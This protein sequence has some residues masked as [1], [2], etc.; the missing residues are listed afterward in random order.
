VSYR[1][2]LVDDYE[3]WRRH[4]D[5][6]LRLLPQYQVVGEA[7]DGAEAIRQWDAHRPDLVVLDVGLPALNGIEVA[8]RILALDRD[9]RIVFLSEHA[10]WDILE[11]ALAAG[12][13]GY[14]LK[15][16]AG[17]DLLP[18]IDAVLDGG[19]FVSASLT[20]PAAVRDGRRASAEP[21][22]HAAGFH[23]DDA[24]LLEEYGLFAEAVLQAGRSLIVVSIGA[25]R[26]ALD[27]ELRA[28]A[29]DVD[30]LASEGRYRWLDVADALSRFLAGDRI[31]ETRFWSSIP[32][33]VLDAARTS[34]APHRRVAVWGEIAPTLWRS[35]NVEAA[36]RLEQLWDA[37]AQ[38]YGVETLCAYPL[39]GF[40][41]DETD[42]AFHGICAAHSHVHPR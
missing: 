1:V 17:R 21:V 29:L 25:R 11:A 16:D 8:R 30:G 12:G 40:S 35:G 3:P 24:S 37:L 23:P 4:V 27:Q 13:R 5:A 31:D 41:Q 9:C 32:P 33:L 22:R 6:A 38:A 7:A 28:R 15:V 26:R 2:L 19:H 20:N 36:I 42:F 34:A 18:S 10:S 14:V 39:N